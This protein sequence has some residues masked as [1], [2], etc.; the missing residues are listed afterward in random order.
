[1]KGAAICLNSLLCCVAALLLLPGLVPA[2]FASHELRDAGI[3]QEACAALG[4]SLCEVNE[5]TA[6]IKSSV[7]VKLV[8]MHRLGRTAGGPFPPIALFQQH[9][10]ITVRRRVHG[11]A[12]TRRAASDHGQAPRL[13]GSQNALASLTLHWSRKMAASVQP[14][15]FL[16]F[17]PLFPTARSVQGLPP[18]ASTPCPLRP[19]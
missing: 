18:A 19:R 3:V 6:V 17:G 4:R 13:V 14:G 1:M 2:Q 9:D 8:A 7:V 15:R 10:L 12:N 11:N 16:V 5:Q